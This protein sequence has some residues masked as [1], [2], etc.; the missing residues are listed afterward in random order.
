MVGFDSARIF[1]IW[2]AH[3][4]D[5]AALSESDVGLQDLKAFVCGASTLNGGLGLFAFITSIH[6]VLEFLITVSKIVDVLD[7][8]IYEGL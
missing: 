1:T 5:V 6:T 3:I 7:N 8:C 4:G 2:R